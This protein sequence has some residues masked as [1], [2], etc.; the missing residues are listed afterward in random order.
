MV[1]KAFNMQLTPMHMLVLFPA[2]KTLGV[3]VY[4]F[5]YLIEY[6]PQISLI[7][8]NCFGLNNI[9]GFSVILYI[10]HCFIDTT[11]TEDK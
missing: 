2:T 1:Y 5:E 10:S 7:V 3:E 8:N 6:M 11:F 4:M 9:Q